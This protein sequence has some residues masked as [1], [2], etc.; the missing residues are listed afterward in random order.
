ME[1]NFKNIFIEE[2]CKIINL[3]SP[4]MDD[5]LY[6][7][8]FQNDFYYISPLAAKRFSIPSHTF[9][10]VVN[11][12]KKF[13][14]PD[15]FPKL[16]AEL[17]ELITGESCSHNMLYRWLSVD[18]DPVWINCRGY[19]VKDKGT[20]LYMAGCI[21]EIGVRQKADNISGL[22]GDSS[23]QTYLNQLSPE[24]AKGYFLRLGLDDFKGINARLGKVYGDMVLRKTAE[25]I[26][27]CLLPGQKLYR[28]DGDEYLILDFLNGKAEDAKNLYQNICHAVERFIISNNYD[29]IYTISG[30]IVESK[31]MDE[32]SY[33]NIIKLT[34]FSLDEAKRRGKNQSYIFRKE[35][36]NDFLKKLTLTSQ[37]RVSINHEFRGFEAYFQP[38]FD[39]KTHQLYGAEALMRYHSEDF[40]MVS[41]AEFIPILEETALIIPAGRWMLHQALRACKDIQ[42]YIPNFKISI[43]VSP[44]QIMKS[45]IVQEILSAIDQY[46]ISPNCVMI[47]LTESELLETDS[48][49][50]KLWSNLKSQGVSLALD[51]FGT[52]YSNFSYL[53]KLQP[54]VVKID[55]TFTMR[56]LN[57]SYEYNL[58]SLLSDM[59]HALKLKICVEG[60]ETK[61]ELETICQLI[62]DYI[63]GYYLGR[64][65]SAKEFMEKYSIYDFCNIR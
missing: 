19:V 47:E 10:D 17:N 9:H 45:R 2:L 44:V 43:N 52:G 26:S 49:F 8:D 13:V 11:N 12:H 40:G 37:L 27:E 6:V 30:G 21:N 64:P 48:R 31:N 55:R 36:Y 16:Q 28:L 15:D 33:A 32:L 34:E 53:S 42:Q 25:C 61:E 56:A 58:L 60:I 38:L 4:S 50:T 29:V 39:T 41:P 5:Y 65:H 20:A 14:Y 18:G 46:D 54:D 24:S 51:D 57:N 7:Y 35:E 63:Q 3:L 59:A 23:L 62:P 22:L 1:Q